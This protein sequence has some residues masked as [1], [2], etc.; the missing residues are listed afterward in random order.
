MPDEETLQAMAEVDDQNSSAPGL[1]GDVSFHNRFTKQKTSRSYYAVQDA[2][3]QMEAD[4]EK[5]LFIAAS[6]FLDQNTSSD[7]IYAEVIRSLELA[8]NFLYKYEN[9]SSPIIRIVDDVIKDAANNVNMDTLRDEFEE[10]RWHILK[11]AL[12]LGFGRQSEPVYEWEYKMPMRSQVPLTPALNDF[13]LRKKSKSAKSVT[14]WTTPS[15][16]QNSKK[17]DTQ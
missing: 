13:L 17:K 6:A 2:D 10:C 8:K 3:L 9:F 11:R 15:G 14:S 1:G 4:M 12:E 7:E 16:R 5:G